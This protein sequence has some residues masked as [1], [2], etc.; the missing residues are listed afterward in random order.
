MDAT[1]GAIAAIEDHI[2]R[3]A[4]LLHAVCAELVDRA[5]NHDRSKLEEPEFTAFANLSRRSST[6]TYG[7][8]PYLKRLATLGPALRH[9]YETNRHHPEFHE[10][11]IGGM[12]LIDVLEMLVDWK[13]A[14]ADYAECD[15]TTA[16][17]RNQ[18][19][20]QFGDELKQLLL[21]T[22]DVLEALAETPT[23]SEGT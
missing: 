4:T 16:I 12:N 17:E 22:A 15:F 7:S 8:E 3:V 1:D 10:E 2:A 21:N 5:A 23:P 20:F 18:R 13:V 9:H 14:N 11:G 19:R 6:M